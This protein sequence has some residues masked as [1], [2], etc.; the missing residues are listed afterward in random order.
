[1]ALEHSVFSEEELI[2]FVNTHYGLESAAVQK[3][4]LGSANCFRLSDGRTSY[5][6]KEFQ[7][8]VSEEDVC[9]EAALLARLRE[10]GIPVAPFIPTKEGAWVV[11]H[12]SHAVCLQEYVEGTTYGYDDFPPRLMPTLARTLGQLHVAMRDMEL[13]AHRD[14]NW[15]ASARTSSSLTP[16]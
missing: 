9:A 3:L 6:L 4:P 13:P 7:S 5:F 15:A 1:M 16:L 14:A 11:S 10:R 2:S 8:G 12:R